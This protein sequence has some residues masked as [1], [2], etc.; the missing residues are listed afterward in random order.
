MNDEPLSG[1]PPELEQPQQHL[2]LYGSALG[3]TTVDDEFLKKTNFGLGNYTTQEMY[4][5][6]ESFRDGLFADA[7]FRRVLF[8]RAV[9][10]AKRRHAEAKWSDQYADVPKPAYTKQEYVDEKADELWNGLG[11]AAD[12]QAADPAEAKMNV[13]A[14]YAGVS[15]EWVPPQWR[16]MKMRHESS[17]SRNA[18]LLDN[19][20]HS[21]QVL[22]DKADDAAGGLLGGSS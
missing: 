18:K 9:Y 22:K 4:Q 5:Q 15:G 1:D 11:D 13:L 12:S 21:V 17:R 6:V 14:R 3:P 2:D 20:F 10:Y 16:M 7:A 19:L 8:Q